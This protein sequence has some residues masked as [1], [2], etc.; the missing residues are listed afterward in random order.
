[1]GPGP[2][3]VQCQCRTLPLQ[4]SPAPGSLRDKRGDDPCLYVC[5][6]P[7]AQP[8][9]PRAGRVFF[10]STTQLTSHLCLNCLIAYSSKQ[11]KTQVPSV[12]S[13]APYLHIQ[14][15]VSKYLLDT[16]YV[17][18]NCDGRRRTA[19]NQNTFASIAMEL[20]RGGGRGEQ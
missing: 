16:N 17:P 20:S 13:Q 8:I 5:L 4:D 10:L 18:G 15:T 14:P 19:K 1:M 6:L 3:H 11:N 9:F 12:G 2:L 7:Q